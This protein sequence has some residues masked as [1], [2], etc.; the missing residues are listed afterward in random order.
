MLSG[1]ARRADIG[2]T[3][4]L[5]AGMMNI[6]TEG[7]AKL[8]RRMAILLAVF[9]LMF[10]AISCGGGEDSDEQQDQQQQQQE[11]GEDEEQD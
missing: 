2:D 10:G 1:A 6:D 9:G 7:G 3:L 5:A 11:E 8:R 4:G